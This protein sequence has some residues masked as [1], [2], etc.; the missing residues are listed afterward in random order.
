MIIPSY[1]NIDIIQGSIG[2]GNTTEGIT[3]W[4]IQNTSTGVF[5]ILNS[6]SVTTR[7]S[8]IENGNIGIITTPSISSSKFN[9]NGFVSCSGIYKKNNRDVLNDTSNIDIIITE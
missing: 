8:I 5:N 2:Y 3:D 9:I 6:T 1:S 4:R 7:L